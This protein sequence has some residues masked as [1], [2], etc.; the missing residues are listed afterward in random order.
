MHCQ[1]VK[2]LKKYQKKKKKHEKPVILFWLTNLS[3]LFLK[4]NVN[5]CKIFDKNK[6]YTHTHTIMCA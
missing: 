4:N 1:I 6:I 3:K 2:F 5:R